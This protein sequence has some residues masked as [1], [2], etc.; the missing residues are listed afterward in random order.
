MW[1]WT[2]VVGG[3]PGE[4]IRHVW[5]HEGH[6]SSW[7]WL[8]LGGEHWRTQS[9]KMLREGSAGRWAVEAVDGNGR[10]LARREFVCLPEAPSRPL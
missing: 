5:K 9:R 7:V 8:N 1:F 10:V 4:M 6:G 2:R 3:K